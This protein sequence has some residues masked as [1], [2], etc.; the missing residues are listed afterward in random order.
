MQAR[1]GRP[2]REPERRGDLR[3]WQ[4]GVVME[5]D[6]GSLFRL[7]ASEATFKLVALRGQDRRVFDGGAL[8][9]RQFDVEPMP[10]RTPCLVQTRPD[11]EAVDPAVERVGVPKRGQITP[12]PDE[13]V[14][15]RVLRLVRIPKDQSRGGIQTMDRGACQRRKGVMIAPLRSLHEFSL[16]VALGVARPQTVELTWNGARDPRDR[17]EFSFLV[18]VGSFVSRTRYDRAPSVP[19]VPATKEPARPMRFAQNAE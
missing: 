8:E 5:D 11:E 15:H 16:H 3:Q 4:I 2:E 14:L 18:I 6:E 10:S 7:Q 17:S 9:R 13:R 19:A 12:G 1:L